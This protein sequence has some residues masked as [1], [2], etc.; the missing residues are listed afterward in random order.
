MSPSRGGRIDIDREP[1]QRGE[2]TQAGEQAE[3]VLD[4]RFA[5]QAEPLQPGSASSGRSDPSRSLWIGGDVRDLAEVFVP[6][7]A[8]EPGRPRRLAAEIEVGP[9][10]LTDIP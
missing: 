3:F 6:E 8:P 5:D 7:P 1:S 10:V 4:A 9:R 2:P